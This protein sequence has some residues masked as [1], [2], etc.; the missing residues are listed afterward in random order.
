MDLEAL[1]RALGS[2]HNRGVADQGIVDTGVGD[3]VS[4]ELVQVDVQS[5]IKS[6]GRRDGADN[7]CDQA[8]Q[9][10]IIGAGNIQVTLADVIHCLIVDQERAVRILDGAVGGQNGVVGLD[11]GS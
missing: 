8:V 7:L 6:K 1:M 11:N 4:L 9:V 5:T 3:Q 2:R 10:R